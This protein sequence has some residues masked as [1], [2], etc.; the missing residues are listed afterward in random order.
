MKAL[1]DILSDVPHQ[2]V[3]G[4]SDVL[5][6]SLQFDSRKVKPGDCFVA[7]RGT[8]TDGHDYIAKAIEAGVRVIVAEEDRDVPPQ[9]TLVI[10]QDSADA[11]G[12]MAAN[13]Y[14]RPSEQLKLIGITGTN[15]KTSTATLVHGL[16]MELGYKTGLISTVENR[17][18]NRVFA[19][20]HTTPDQLQLQAL[21]A[22]MLEAGCDYAVMEV[23]SHALDQRRVAGLRF[24]I[25]VFTNLSH[26]H[27]DY[28]GSFK[29]YIF[30][31]KKLF[32]GLDKDA[33]ALVNTDDRRGEVMLQNTKGKPFT[34]GLRK[35]ARFKAKVLENN[36]NG[37]ILE[38][39]G[40]EF[41]APLVGRF[42]AYNLL[43]AYGVSQ[44]LGFE[45]M[46]VLAV[47][48]KLRPPAGRFETISTGPDACL[49]I[50]D[51]AHTPDAL[52]KVLETIRDTHSGKGE[53]LT[54]VG[55]GGDRDV[56][57]RP[58]MG[59]IA[60]AL[61]DRVILTS[62]NPRSEEPAAIL[63]DMKAGIPAGHTKKVLMVEDRREA[64][65]TAVAL[66]R[67]TDIVLVAG[68]G[69]ETYQEIKGT[70]YPF[71]DR[72]ELRKAL[73]EKYG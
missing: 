61:S 65:R 41:H 50:V 55:C 67:D 26:D 37:L 18:G 72:D 46:E 60:A 63:L 14:G 68:K 56:K 57:K 21:L 40:Q 32:D 59:R 64:I 70:R 42:N 31:K 23:S 6:N 73:E 28:H 39:D 1:L 3:K 12:K 5:V 20:T 9:V 24:E 29:E 53:V 33:F 22:D 69:H 13:W 51:Y 43:A 17:I 30:A 35:A 66:A 52:E 15:G 8:K 25:G 49:G 58:E 47:L 45:R 7:V 36:L 2:V 19:S 44:L 4:S 34:Y 11:L 62:D 10:V 27:L 38:M 71:D 48:S 54:V 16:I